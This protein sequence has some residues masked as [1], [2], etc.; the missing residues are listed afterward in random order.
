MGYTGLPMAAAGEQAVALVR[1][2]VVAAAAY[3]WAGCR[4]DSEVVE[5]VACPAP[6]WEVLQEVPV[7][8]W[9]APSAPASI[10]TWW[11]DTSE[12]RAAPL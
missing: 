12:P 6:Q 11:K 2:P 5:L 10:R 7:L 3:P 8:A 4:Q 9:V 1:E